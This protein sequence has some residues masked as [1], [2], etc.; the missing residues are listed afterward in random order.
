MSFE[1]TEKKSFIHSIFD[2][3]LLFYLIA[4]YVFFQDITPYALTIRLLATGCMFLSGCLVC[5]HKH[6]VLD[7]HI[8]IYIVFLAFGMMSMLWAKDDSMIFSIMPSMI[9]TILILY[10]ISNRVQ[11]QK[12]VEHIMILHIVAIIFLD[13]FVMKLMVDFYSLSTFFLKRFGDNFAYNSNATSNLNAISALFCI[14]FIKKGVKKI[15][16]I[17]P[18]IFFIF[19]IIICG[20]KQ[21]MIAFIMGVLLTI[22]LKGNLQKKFST[23]II[24][25][26]TVV[27]IWELLM[28]VPQLYE[29]IGHRFEG[30]LGTMN[31]TIE[32]RS[33]LNRNNLLKQAFEVW[34]SHPLF[35]VGFN[36]FPVVQTVQSGYYYAH[37]NYLELLADL[38]IVG[39][40]CFYMNYFRILR[41]KINKTSTLQ[42]FMKSIF[43]MIV[44]TDLAVVSYQD[45]R[46]QLPLYL[47]FIVLYKLSNSGCKESIGEI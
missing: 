35:G 1:K 41:K 4:Y 6:P 36:N 25:I 34:T 44:F 33:T 22:Y 17:I 29:I 14:Y 23:I 37:N 24:A 47:I 11:N 27:V 31:A 32:D 3:S 21:G 15:I 19:I 20:S 12:D 38:G 8:A 26:I 9:R 2:I 45:L 10:F 40:V 43:Y 28:N 42:V 16:P 5:V 30:L 7:Y 18:L 13:I 39:F 46:Y